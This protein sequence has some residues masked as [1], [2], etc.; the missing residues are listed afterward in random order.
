MDLIPMQEKKRIFNTDVYAATVFFVD[1]G[2]LHAVYIRP[3]H[4]R[5]PLSSLARGALVLVF[6]SRA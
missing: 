2:K 6:G 5:T 1:D 3:L 4:S